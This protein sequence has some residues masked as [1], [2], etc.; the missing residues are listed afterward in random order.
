MKTVYAI[1]SILFLSSQ[2]ISQSLIWQDSFA[3]IS[4][5]IANWTSDNSAGSEEWTWTD[6]PCEPRVGIQPC[7][8]APTATTGHVFFDSDKNGPV[9][10]VAD[11]THNTTIDC[12]AANEVWLK[13]TSQ[14]AFFSNN[15][16]PYIG[17]DTGGGFEYFNDLF[18]YV[19]VNEVKDS[20]QIQYVNIS[21]VAAGN[22]NVVLR[23]R[24]KGGHEYNWKIDDVE[25]WDGDPRPANDLQ[26]QDNFYARTA[27]AMVPATQVAPMQFMVDFINAGKETQYNIHLTLTVSKDG[28]GEIIYSDTLYIDSLTSNALFQNT[29]LNGTFSPPTVEEEYTVTYYVYS[30]SVDANA[31]DNS[32]RFPFQVTDTVFSKEASPEEEL[33]CVPPLL[34]DLSWSFGN[35]YYVPNGYNYIASSTTFSLHNTTNFAGEELYIYLYEW[36]NTDNDI[37]APFAERTIVAQAEYTI[38]GDDEEEVATIALQHPLDPDSLVLL[39]DDKH[40]LLIAHFQPPG[41]SGGQTAFFCRSIC[42]DYTATY[43]VNTEMAGL[44]RYGAFLG[45]NGNIEDNLCFS[46]DYGIPHFRLNLRHITTATKNTFAG[47]VKVKAYPNPAS[48]YMHLVLSFPY[49]VHSMDI[50]IVNAFGRIVQHHQYA[51]FQAFKTQIDVSDLPVGH[52]QIHIYNEE[53]R[54]VVPLIVIRN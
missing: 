44:P 23:F 40:Y 46:P 32:I 5:F 6:D 4:D 3:D 39:D 51:D 50:N 25:I 10:F 16:I 26:L 42:F 45:D 22:A 48:E 14:Y 53:G 9:G 47:E 11:L 20:I 49:W 37:K 15:S 2:L 24:W 33:V 31:K 21:S 18:P 41:G 36:E 54:A 35:H 52:Y 7:F 43:Y 8:A 27:D 12:S 38:I 13:F 30:D 28:S 29:P 34:D 17:I 19:Y 1:I